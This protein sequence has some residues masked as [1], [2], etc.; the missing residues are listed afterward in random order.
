M[1]R[2][3]AE[4]GSTFLIDLTWGM[5]GLSITYLILNSAYLLIAGKPIP[6]QGLAE[7]CV[8]VSPGIVYGLII[9]KRRGRREMEAKNVTPNT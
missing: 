4:K 7:I 8:L 9:G 2:T 1:K 3:A 6:S 5:L